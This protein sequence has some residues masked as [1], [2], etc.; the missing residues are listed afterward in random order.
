MLRNSLITIALVTLFSLPARAQAANVI[1]D[2][3]SPGPLAS[4]I[5][6]WT[7]TLYVNAIPFVL[8][9]TCV[10]VTTVTPN[11]VRCTAPLPVITT[12][13]TPTGPQNFEVTVMDVVLESPK[14]VPFVL[15][16]PSVTTN[17][18]IQ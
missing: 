8:N 17:L 13:L 6:G 15:T 11:V 18:R 7:A 10:L 16:R 9:D 4:V 5:Q 3:P 12:A 2:Y 14:S 1:F